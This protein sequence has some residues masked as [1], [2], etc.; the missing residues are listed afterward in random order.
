V[1]KLPTLQ[2]GDR[3][4]VIAPAS[5]CTDQRLAGLQELLTSWQLDCI[6][7]P[8][9]FGEDLLCA[10]T[11]EIRFKLLRDALQ[12]PKTKAVICARGGYGCMRLIPQLSKMIPPATPK[13]FIGMSDITALN[14]YFQQAWQ[15][16]VMHGA[17]A[18]DKF[19]GESIA[20]LKAILF[21]HV[22]QVPFSGVPLNALA[23]KNW[24]LEAN[25]TGGNLSLV[26]ASLG[27]L[28]QINGREKIIFL[29]EVGE[30][31]YRVDR[32]LEH[33]RQANV[34]KDAAAIL[35]GDFL[36]GNE[37]DGSSL[38]QPVL[39]RF[40]QTCKIPVVQVKGIGHGYINFPIPLGTSAQLNLGNQI[41]LICA[42]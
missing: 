14:L 27:T 18:K 22:K 32:M 3:V 39:A 7:S 4:E 1:R 6:V 15:W 2:P 35:L 29:E 33:L 37:P 26:Q 8:D 13:L 38:I 24:Q 34:F 41:K 9:I 25:I 23:E 11:D 12:N 19:S 36:A 31:G 42:T 17:L 40:A 28:W 30:R 21:G 16:P 5:R 20:S 10:N